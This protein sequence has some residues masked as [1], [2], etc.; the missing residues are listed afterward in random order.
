[1]TPSELA[2]IRTEYDNIH[3]GRAGHWFDPGEYEDVIKE[4]FLK[5]VPELLEAAEHLTEPRTEQLTKTL[6][7]EFVEDPDNLRQYLQERAVYAAIELIESEMRKQG[8]S[9]LE[10]AQRVGKPEEWLK[11]VLDGSLQNIRTLAD[12]LAVLGRELR[13][14]AE[15]IQINRS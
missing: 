14:V 2:K 12:I 1:M 7:E 13:L 6:V 9:H 4:F 8:I 5:R 10:L 15:P 3:K 11:W